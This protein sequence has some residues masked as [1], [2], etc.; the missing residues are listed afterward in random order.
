MGNIHFSPSK[1]LGHFSEK[2]MGTKP[3]EKLALAAV[4]KTDPP[5]ESAT[6]QALAIAAHSETLEI[7]TALQRHALRLAELGHMKTGGDVLRAAVRLTRV[8]PGTHA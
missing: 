4:E 2:F 7:R 1:V 6:A 8:K 5:T 3:V